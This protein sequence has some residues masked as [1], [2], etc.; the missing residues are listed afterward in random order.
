MKRKYALGV[1]LVIIVIVGCFWLVSARKTPQRFVVLAGERFTVRVADDEIER[2]RGLS[3]TVGLGKRQGMLFV[4]DKPGKPCLWMKDMNY[5]ID[6][7][8]LYDNGKIAHIEQRVKPSTYPNSFCPLQ[9]VSRVLEVPAGTVSEL[10]LAN[11]DTV[12]F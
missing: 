10:G 8:W 6:M 4:F 3:G 2:E 9:E 11:G 1:L 12:S 5:A 7:L